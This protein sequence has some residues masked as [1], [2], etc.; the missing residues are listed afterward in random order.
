[1]PIQLLCTAVV[2]RN[3]KLDKILEGGSENFTSIVPNGVAYGDDKLSQASFMS[4]VDAEE[5]CKSLELR[6][7]QRS[8]EDPD[9]VVVSQHDQSITPNCDWLLLFEWEN[10]LIGTLRGSDSR[11]VVGAH[12]SRYENMLHYSAEE[13]E[14]N[15][16]FVSRENHID[17]YRNKETGEL[18]YHARRTETDDEIFKAA[19]DTVWQ[20][21]REIGHP[22]KTGEPVEK[23]KA[24]IES[25]QK[26]AAKHSDSPRVHLALGMAWYAI[27]NNANGIRLL[28]KAIKLAPEEKIYFK[29]LGGMLLTDCLLYTSPSPRDATLSR[30]PSSA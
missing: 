18:V 26:V 9:F 19:F 13:I 29:E 3:N 5:F 22:A 27:G 23:I 10:R 17:T 30:M 6:G 15:F 21:K 16:E 8:S 1:M 11:T 25:L 4:P 7:L 12:E 28:R 2:I 24:A 20:N 14:K